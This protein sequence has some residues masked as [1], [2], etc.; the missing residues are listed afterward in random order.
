MQVAIQPAQIKK[1]KVLQRRLGLDDDAYREM[2]WGIARVK[3]CKDLSGPKIDL[4]ITH[5]ERCAG[6]S[7]DPG[8]GGQAAGG[9]RMATVNQIRMIRQLWARVSRARDKWPAL[10]VFLKNRFGVERLEWLR[11]QQV[12]N[13]IEGLKKMQ[14]RI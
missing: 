6:Q 13:V 7:R 12:G 2:L 1:I 9:P 10:R 4:V 11:F 8:G 3:S 14:G 5:L